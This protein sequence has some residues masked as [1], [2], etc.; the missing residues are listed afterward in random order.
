[1]RT[2]M[3]V[4]NGSVPEGG[5]GKIDAADIVIRFNDCRSAGPGGMKTDIVAVCNTGRPART[6]LSGDWKNNRSVGS[7]REIWS[8][9]SREKFA[10]MRPE[11]LKNHPELDD[12][13][14]DYTDEFASFA[15]TTG[16]VHRVIAASV[17]EQVDRELARFSPAPYVVPSS[18]MVVI[19]DILSNFAKPED[20]VILTGFDHIGWELHPFA[21]EKQLVETLIGDGRVRRLA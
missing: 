18:G 11:I 20:E 7:A 3:I 21:A 15:E 16:R 17:H 8:V 1:M 19:S 4:G 6:M 9:R 13:C 12:F 10:Q 5:A 2:I 14:D